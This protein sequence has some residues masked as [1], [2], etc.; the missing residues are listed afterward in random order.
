MS[1]DKHIKKFRVVP[2]KIRKGTTFEDGY[3]VVYKDNKGHSAYLLGTL[4]KSLAEYI[5]K[6]ANAYP[7]LVKQ[8]KSNMKIYHKLLDTESLLSKLGEL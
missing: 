5:V 2:D 7:E 6:S 4:D 3:S 1:E 8:L